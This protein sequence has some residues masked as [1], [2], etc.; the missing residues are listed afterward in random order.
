[1]HEYTYISSSPGSHDY[2]PS[3]KVHLALLDT[4]AFSLQFI[5]RRFLH[6]L[7]RPPCSL[8]LNDIFNPH[9]KNHP[10]VTSPPPWRLLSIPHR[11]YIEEQYLTQKE[12]YP[13]VPHV[14]QFNKEGKLLYNSCLDILATLYPFDMSP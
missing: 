6:F 13:N 14:I 5:H 4:P 11:L 2:S 1:M 7:Y 9:A 12:R 8:P 10:P 3:S